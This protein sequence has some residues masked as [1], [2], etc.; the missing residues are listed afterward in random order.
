MSGSPAELFIHAIEPRSRANGPGVR[1]AIWVQGCSLG[2]PGCFNPET[3]AGGGDATDVDS[4]IETIAADAEHIEGITIS[5]GEPFEQPEALLALV[6]GVRAKTGLSIVVFSGFSRA[7]I[8]SSPLGPKILTHLDVVIDGR[9]VDRLRVARNL[10]GS[11][12]QTIHTLSP[13]F[14]VAD[15]E[16]TPDAEV[17]IDPD[18]HITISGVDPLDVS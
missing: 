4:L 18:G 17:K 7:E 10:K 14:S 11:R 5:G 12:N 13:R 2:C 1:F 9:Y 6:A 3:H 15:I 16:A 8:E